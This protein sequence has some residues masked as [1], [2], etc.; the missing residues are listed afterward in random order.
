MEFSV[1]L[2]KKADKSLNKIPKQILIL[3]DEWIETIES[4]GYEA[5]RSVNGYRDHALAGKRKGQ[6]SSSLN[7]SWRI[8][9]LY[10]EETHQII[11]EVIEVTNHEY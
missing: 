7:K 1:V 11:I 4:D 3:L 9:Y 8:I 6:R 2:S 5:M 10:K